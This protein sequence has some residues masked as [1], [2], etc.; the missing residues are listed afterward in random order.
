LQEIKAPEARLMGLRQVESKLINL[1]L[2]NF[3]AR[4]PDAV[5]DP[6]DPHRSE[7]LAQYG[8]LII[9]QKEQANAQATQALQAFT[10]AK[11]NAKEP[12]SSLPASLIALLVALDRKDVKE[13]SPPKN[14]PP[15][16]IRVGYA[17]ALAYRGQVGEARA[18]A[19]SEGPVSHQ[20]Q[21]L[22]ALLDALVDKKA[23]IE[24]DLKAALERVGPALKEKEAGVSSWTLYHLVQLA[25]R[26]GKGRQVGDMIKL[27]IPDPDLRGRAELEMVSAEL[28]P[29]GGSTKCLNDQ[30][31]ETRPFCRHAVLVYSR[32][33]A[34]YGSSSGILKDIDRWWKPELKPLGYAG[35]ALGMQDPEK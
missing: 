14:N 31:S 19:M 7:A 35:V 34:R 11:K 13:L 6:N 16:D 9:D 2:S 33:I 22:I 30:H 4:L 10:P 23:D 12:T 26:A 8:L 3:A 21:A 25:V 32:Q 18:L 28:D 27:E 5:L 20:L 24:V 17:W 15:L 29:L 1:N